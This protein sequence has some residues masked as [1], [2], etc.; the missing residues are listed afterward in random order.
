MFKVQSSKFKVQSSK[1]KSLDFPCVSAPLRLC[2]KVLCHNRPFLQIASY[3][4]DT[5]N[6]AITSV[7]IYKIQGSEYNLS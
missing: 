4:A 3:M 1:F 5:G 2:V 7:S 6:N